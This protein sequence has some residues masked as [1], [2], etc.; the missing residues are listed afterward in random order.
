MDKPLKSVTHGQC[1]A[2]PT[3]TFPAA[4]HRR[5][6]TVTK[7]YCLVTEACVCEQLA[8]GC[9]LKARGRELNSRPSESK[10]NALT[11]TPPGHAPSP[12]NKRGGVGALHCFCPHRAENRRYATTELRGRADISAWL[13]CRSQVGWRSWSL[14]SAT[15]RL[16]PVGRW[17]AGQLAVRSMDL[18]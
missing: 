11:T 16:G 3:V 13:L 15:P 5:P 4:G 17:S 8:Q 7:L 12:R 2:R 9:Y 1:D 6:L 14:W 10:S 18:N